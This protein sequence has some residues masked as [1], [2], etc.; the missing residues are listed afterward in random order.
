MYEYMRNFPF[1]VCYM[2]LLTGRWSRVTGNYRDHGIGRSWTP[3]KS[4]KVWEGGLVISRSTENLFTKRVSG[5]GARDYTTKVTA[6]NAWTCTAAPPLQIPRDDC[7]AA[8]TTAA[9]DGDTLHGVF[10][11]RRVRAPPPTPRGKTHRRLAIPVA[12]LLRWEVGEGR[13]SSKFRLPRKNPRHPVAKKKNP[14]SSSA[15]SP[16]RARPTTVRIYIRV[17]FNTFY[18][19]IYFI[20]CYCCC[21]VAHDV[22]G[23]K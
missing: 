1:R 17:Q 19:G 7:R 15:Q 4:E 8:D 9:T 20:I 6:D 16:L 13:G 5:T 23:K 11:S 21:C 22:S 14:S 10:R 12:E 2:R 3:D 18:D